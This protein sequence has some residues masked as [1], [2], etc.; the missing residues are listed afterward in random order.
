MLFGILF[1]I[2]LLAA[3]G[4]VVF[5]I[6]GLADGSVSSFNA[7]IWGVTLLT[8]A[9]VLGG[10]WTLQK[11]GQHGAAKGVLLVVAVPALLTALFFLIVIIAKPR[12]N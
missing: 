11:R 6:W 9:A 12:W 1:A 3:A 2:D 8:L 5:F 7:E 4:F 10:G